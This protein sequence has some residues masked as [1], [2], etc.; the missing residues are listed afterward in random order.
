MG[1]TERDIPLRLRDMH[2]HAQKALDFVSGM[3]AKEFYADEKTLLAVV[4]CLEVIGEAASKLPA[5][6]TDQRAFIEY[7]TLEMLA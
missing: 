4:R 1:K 5:S 2:A 6:F 3:E 7:F